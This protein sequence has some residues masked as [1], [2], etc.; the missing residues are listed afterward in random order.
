M[1]HFAARTTMTKLSI[2]WFLTWAS[3]AYLATAM[4]LSPQASSAV[5]SR[6]VLLTGATGGL[7]QALAQ[8][9]AQAPLEALIL[10]GRNPERLEAV[11]QEL[12]ATAQ[13]PIETIVCDLADLEQVQ[14]VAPKNIDVLI[15]NGG[16]SSRSRFVDTALSVDETLMTVNFLS[17]AA[18]CKAAVPHMTTKKYGRI[19]WISSVQGLVGIPNR[20]SYAA[21]KFAVQGYTESLRAELHSSGITVHTVSPGYIR[22][23][24]S[25]SALTGDGTAHGQLDAT[26][27]QGAEPSEVAHEL[28]ERCLAQNQVDFTIAAPFSATVAI[29]LRLLCPGLLRSKLVKRYEKSLKEKK[30]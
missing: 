28:L 25:R 23:N 29:W 17:G 8:E 5:A 12:Q 16:L 10:T 6:R 20:T 30:D 13:C 11:K 15:H 2:L 1:S 19:V 3:F 14:K 24:L 21:S 27:A 26:T 7:G 4:P 18:L 22:T 9:L